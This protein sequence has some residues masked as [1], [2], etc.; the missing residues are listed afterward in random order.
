MKLTDFFDKIFVINLKRRPDRW[1]ECIEE[2]LLAKIPLHAVERWEAI[3][4]PLNG[5]EAG[6]RSHRAL[7][8]HIAASGYKN[9][10][11]LEDDF[12][13]ITKPILSANGFTPDSR[14]MQTY[15]SVMDGTGTFAERFSF[16]LG[17]LPPH[18][19][20]IYLAGGYAE[21][22][23]GRVNEHF[24]RVGKMKCCS[25]YAV[26]GDFARRFT[27]WLDE[28]TGGD[29]TYGLGQADDVLGLFSEQAIYLCLQPRLL[30]QRKS[31]SDLTGLTDSYLMSMTDPAHENMV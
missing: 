22:P 8:R 24:L 25:S 6:A 5:S 21:K 30:Y 11:I 14:V 29:L 31:K 1:A 7:M 3:D 27:A 2:F 23:F 16:L 10:L 12:A 17:W 4:N 18:W 20:L 19:E 28:K 13:A 9:V 26:T 15:C